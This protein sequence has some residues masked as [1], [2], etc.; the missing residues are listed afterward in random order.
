MQMAAA[1]FE[2]VGQGGTDGQG[3]PG[4]LVWTIDFQ[5]SGAPRGSRDWPPKPALEDLVDP[6]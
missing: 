4:T 5:C 1:P 6:A 3:G 2:Q